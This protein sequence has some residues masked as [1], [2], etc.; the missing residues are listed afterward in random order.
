MT[1][2]K[3]NERDSF[4]LPLIHFGKRK[5]ALVDGK[6]RK[7]SSLDFFDRGRVIWERV[8]GFLVAIIR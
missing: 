2:G 6:Q 1:T 4:N 5:I 7:F 8:P 3:M